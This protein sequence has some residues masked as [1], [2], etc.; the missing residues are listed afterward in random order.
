M[1]EEFLEGIASAIQ[2]KRP[3]RKTYEGTLFELQHRPALL[4]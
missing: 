2:E 4:V 1:L 3:I